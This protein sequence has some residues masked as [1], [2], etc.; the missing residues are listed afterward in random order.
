MDDIGCSSIAIKSCDA[1]IDGDGIPN[2]LDL[3]SDGD[4]CPDAKEAGVNGT[5]SSG[6]VKNGTGGAVT[7]TTT[8]A[9]AIAAGPYGNNGL[10]NGVETSTESGVVTYTSTYTNNAL[11]KDLV[12]LTITTQPL[13]RTV[14]VGAPAVLTTTVGAAPAN[15]TLTYQ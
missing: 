7:S 15:R 11:V 12:A 5:L 4:G 14:F 1:D 8:V 2:Q 13:N 9:N 3:D 10:A 6:S